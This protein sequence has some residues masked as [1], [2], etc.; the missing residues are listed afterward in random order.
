MVSITLP[1]NDNSAP[2]VILG[3]MTIVAAATSLIEVTQSQ[4]GLGDTGSV[5]LV[6]Q[7]LYFLR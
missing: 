5:L 3:Y 2:G 4:E 6:G 1:M 7:Y